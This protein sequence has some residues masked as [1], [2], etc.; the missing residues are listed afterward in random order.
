MPCGLSKSPI[1]ISVIK[2]ATQLAGFAF[3]ECMSS[4][5]P[6]IMEYEL[7]AVSKYVYM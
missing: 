6:E 5:K 3:M 1:E 4:T 2:K 7:D